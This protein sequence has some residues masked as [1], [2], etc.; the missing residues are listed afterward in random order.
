MKYTEY[1]INELSLTDRPL[2]PTSSASDDSVPDIQ[3]E[4][5]FDIPNI[6]IPVNWV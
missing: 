6:S 1:A 5:D 3:D 4:T 2:A